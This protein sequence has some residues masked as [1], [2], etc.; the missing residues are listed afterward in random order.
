[1]AWAVFL[2]F[3]QASAM[4]AKTD[5]DPHSVPDAHK[6]P[7]VTITKV[8]SAPEEYK[9]SEIVLTGTF[10]GWKD[11]CEGSAPVTRSDWILEDD[12]G[13]IYV[14]GQLP[15]RVSPLNPKNE[16]IIVSGRV[17]II[18]NGLINFKAFKAT[19]MPV[20]PKRN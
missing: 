17:E 3:S 13:C 14:S 19:R 11:A 10:R 1:M 2:L 15:P 4:G 20:P 5:R 8:L 7:G 9:D 18:R 16:R 12:T 6:K